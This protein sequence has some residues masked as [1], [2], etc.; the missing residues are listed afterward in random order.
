MKKPSLDASE[1]DD[2]VRF[3]V[4]AF[5]RKVASGIPEGARVLDAGAGEC[6]YRPLFDRRRYVAVDRAVGDAEWDYGRLDAMADLTRLPFPDASFDWVLCTETLEHLSR[7]QESL[8]ELRRVVKLGGGLALSVP[9]LQGLH[10]EPHDYFRYTPHA[11]RALLLEASFGEIE[12]DSTGGYFA[13][14]RYQLGDLPAHLPLGVSGSP[15]S[16]LSWPFR[17][18]F[19]AAAAVLRVAAGVLSRREPVGSRPLQLFVR[20]RRIA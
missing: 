13:L 5:V 9:F 18:W 15:R 16:W 14:L 17:A 11:L 8:N 3:A 12:I 1:R 2:P 4:N 20:A 10:Q 7:P 6:L 19:R